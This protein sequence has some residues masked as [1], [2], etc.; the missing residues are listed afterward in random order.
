MADFTPVPLKAQLQKDIV[1]VLDGKSFEMHV[2]NVDFT[3]QGGGQV[4]WQ[5]GT[6]DALATGSQPTTWQANI[7]AV[8]DYADPLSF[9]SFC[10]AN[11][12]KK[13]AMQYRPHRS[14]TV[15]IYATIDLPAPKIGG[16]VN[17][18]TFNEFTLACASTKPSTIAPTA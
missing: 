6:P 3:P 4:S 12:G 14:S 2:S 18:S 17:G 9:A 8:Q 5:G 15:T 16:A 1:L 11:Y 10:L 13:Y 7:T